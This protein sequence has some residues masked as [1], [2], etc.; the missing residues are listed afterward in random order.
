[1]I[2]K[3]P[4]CEHCGSHKYSTL[5]Y[6]ED[7]YSMVCGECKKSSVGVFK[8]VEVPY[9]TVTFPDGISK[10]LDHELEI[11]YDDFGVDVE[12]ITHELST[13]TSHKRHN[14]TEF[15]FLFP[16]ITGDERVAFESD[17]HCTGGNMLV[18]VIKEIIITKATKKSENY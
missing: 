18:N 17:I 12:I 3:Y 7:T 9:P 13:Y 2:L 4:T 10:V 1:M 16:S 14:V 11:F 5:S 15:H 8:F 6:G